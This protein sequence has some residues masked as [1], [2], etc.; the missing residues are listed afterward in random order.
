MTE[1]VKQSLQDEKK[2]NTTSINSDMQVHFLNTSK[3]LSE[4]FLIIYRRPLLDIN[5]EIIDLT[6]KQELCIKKL[7]LENKKLCDF[8]EHLEL[9]NLVCLIFSYF[10]YN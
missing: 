4:G 10:S 2:T 6:I 9:H 8:Q 5:Q 7:Q 3:K 1:N